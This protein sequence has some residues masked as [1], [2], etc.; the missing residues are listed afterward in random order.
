MKIISLVATP[1][2]FFFPSRSAHVSAGK[3]ALISTLFTMFFLFT[4]GY[5]FSGGGSHYPDWA[6]AIVRGM[7]LSPTVAQREVGFPLLY[8]LGGFPWMHSFIGIT[9]IFAAFA[10]LIPALVYWSL[11][12]S[13]PTVA[14]YV[15]LVCIISLS[16]YTYMKFFYPDQGY[17]FFNLLSVALLIEFLWTGRIRMLYFFTMAALAASFTR[18]AGNLMFPVLL[19]IAFIA[20]RGR[21]AH[22]LGCALIFALATGAYQWHRYEIFD[23][24]HQASVPSGKGM[25]IFYSTYL[26]L[27]DFGYR[28][29]PDIGPNTKILLEKLR[30][31]LK[32]GA[33]QSVLV[34][35]GLPDDP[36]E[37]MDK[38]VYAYT[39][40][41][42]YE[43]IRTRPN[44]EYWAILM[45]IDPNDQ[46][47]LD[48][49]KEIARSHPWY[50]VEYSMRN[51]WHAVFDPGYA[52][53]RYNVNGY[54]KTGNDFIP[55]SQGWGARSEDSVEQYGPRAVGEMKY[56]PLKSKSQ[57]VQDFFHWVENRWIVHF[58]KYIWSTSL[59]IGV[60][61]IGA[62]LGALSWVIPRAR[63]CKTVKI[64]G[65]DKMM[66]PVIAASALMLYEDLATAMF[67]QPLYRYFHMTEP[68]RLVIVGFGAVFIVGALQSHCRTTIGLMQTYWEMAMARIK[69]KSGKAKFGNIA[70]AI[71][72]HDLLEGYFGKRR[73]Q[74]I[75]GLIVLNFILFAWW[76]SAMISHAWHP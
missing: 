47:Y 10:V 68:L 67:S 36:P 26:Y 13:S 31:G 23:M 66:A 28:L 25:Q 71:Q 76:T 33:P 57:I 52:T 43:I 73:V 11:V 72:D 15:G 24:R 58:H 42:L 35:R 39:P 44:E 22:Y 38:H 65:I 14:F 34:K 20:V 50:I 2:A 63:F 74:L 30:E 6:E 49:A 75:V 45:A 62:V 59:L 5:H 19:T 60:A 7:T 51:L 3:L 70:Q 12:R 48:V 61:W 18:T 55:G 21:I 54:G 41:E 27:G 40:D 8:I 64:A 4:A 37:F 17:M 46:F 1:A 56:F 69:A 16:P 29:S 32:P 9:L 53:T